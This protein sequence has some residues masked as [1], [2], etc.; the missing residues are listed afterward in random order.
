MIKIDDKVIKVEHFPD[1][2]QRLNCLPKTSSYSDLLFK[3]NYES[4][5]E[6]V[7]LIFLVKHLRN[8]GFNQDFLLF[9]DYI[10]NARMDRTHYKEEVFT[11]KY[12]CD[13]I[14]DL[15]FS[16][17]VV[18]D[19]HS[20]VS[21]ALLDRVIVNT[22]EEAIVQVI[23]ELNDKNLVLF[24]PDSGAAKRYSSMFPEY[25]YI[26]GNKVRRWEDGVIIGTEIVNPF[27]VD[28]ENKTIL[29]I[30]D[31]CSRGTTFV[32]SAEALKNHNVGD[33]YLWV[34]HCENTI[35]EG[36]VLTSGLIKKVFTTDS[37]FTEEHEK[38]EVFQYGKY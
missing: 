27:N 29:I 33:I 6:L 1:G 11:L 3:W 34:T 25:K 37:I 28:I 19:P 7:T 5:E 30:D 38:V 9:L 4:D 36:E 10:P 23:N 20:N 14:N 32:K 21:T 15:Q 8:I 22:P 26:Y 18:L 16:H 24:F 2:T 13:I 17:V 35:L 12:F 31:I